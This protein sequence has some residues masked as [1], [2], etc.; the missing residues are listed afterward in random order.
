VHDQIIPVFT[1]HPPLDM[2]KVTRQLECE[3]IEPKHPSDLLAR[4]KVIHAT[5]GEVNQKKDGQGQG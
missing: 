3:G 1:G 5:I 4:L 2:A